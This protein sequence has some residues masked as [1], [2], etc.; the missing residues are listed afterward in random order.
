M[1]GHITN[2][3]SKLTSDEEI[4]T[5]IEISSTHDHNHE[6]KQMVIEKNLTMVSRNLSDELIDKGLID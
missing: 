4:S 3:I 5:F 2:F 1:L 6:D